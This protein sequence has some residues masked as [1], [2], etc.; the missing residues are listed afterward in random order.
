[1][2]ATRTPASPRSEAVRD[3]IRARL[4]AGTLARTSGRTW[5]GAA[6]GNRRC[7]A[8]GRAIRAGDPECEELDRG[9]LY[10]HLICFKLW[11]KASRE[12]GDGQS[13]AGPAPVPAGQGREGP[14]RVRGQVERRR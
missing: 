7:A 6:A 4:A 14:G 10:A 2:A 9:Q 1:M 11:V 5:I 12:E 3:L 13:P 8:C